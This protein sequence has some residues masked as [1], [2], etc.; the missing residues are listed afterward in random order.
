MFFYTSLSPDAPQLNNTYGD[1]NAIINYII[2]GGSEYIIDKIEPYADKKVKIFYRNTGNVCPWALCQTITIEGSTNYNKNFFIETINESES[3]IICYN[4]TIIF[5][6]SVEETPINDSCKA[7][8]IKSGITKKFGG[9]TEK[10]T[11]IKFKRGMEYR[12]DDRFFGDL[13]TPVVSLNNNWLKVARVCMAENFET[14]DS[15]T[16]RLAPFESTR[17]SENF[18]PSGNYIGQ[19]LIIYNTGNDNHYYINQT[20]Y[21]ASNNKYR[22]WAN[23]N[24]IYIQIMSNGSYD[25]SYSRCYIMGEFNANNK[26]ITNG[27]LQSARPRSGVYNS[28]SNQFYHYGVSGAGFCHNLD[29]NDVNLIVY[30]NLIDNSYSNINLYGE[31]YIGGGLPSGNGGIAYPNNVDGSV[32]FSDTIVTLTS[33]EAI[34]K[35]YDVKWVNSSV[36]KERD[37]L[38]YIDD[39]LYIN[40][41]CNYSSGGNS[42]VFIK[43]E[44]P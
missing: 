33:G 35:L 41:R 3:F 26:N 13:M 31:Y 27:I 38:T 4:S 40:L 22:I 39:E 44:R 2:D 25:G 16:T 32:T 20:N 21:N 17:P 11:V 34:G 28:T 24:A 42:N 9:V 10:R 12:I 14:L 15:T 5:N 19:S 6:E 7:S 36:I 18:T 1:F 37:F 29:R 8:T 30:N 23:E 43:L